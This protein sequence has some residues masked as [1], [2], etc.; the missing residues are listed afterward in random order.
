M[1]WCRN[2]GK[3]VQASPKALV[4]TFCFAFWL[5]LTTRLGCCV[6]PSCSCA[7]PKVRDHNL[8]RHKLPF[9]SPITPIKP[10]PLADVKHIPL[11]DQGIILT[12]LRRAVPSSGMEVS[13]K[14]NNFAS[15]IFHYL[16]RLVQA[17]NNCLRNLFA[18]KKLVSSEIVMSLRIAHNRI[19][20]ANRPVLSDNAAS[21]GKEIAFVK[22][23]WTPEKGNNV[24]FVDLITATRVRS[25]EWGSQTTGIIDSSRVITFKVCKAPA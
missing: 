12:S 11:K 14:S 1:L 17:M 6:S 2:V 16:A 7:A 18:W 23:R 10:S 24:K 8:F 13:I 25:H 20:A 9:P 22:T 21:T 15:A 19:S 3:K 4:W 5:D